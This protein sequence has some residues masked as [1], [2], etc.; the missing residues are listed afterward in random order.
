MRPRP[1]RTKTTVCGPSTC[2]CGQRTKILGSG[3]PSHEQIRT[4]EQDNNF[5]VDGWADG[6]KSSEQQTC[7]I[8]NQNR[9]LGTNQFCLNQTV[10]Q[11]YERTGH[12][13][14]RVA[15]PVK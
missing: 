11:A 6:R 7:S 12:M 5:E 14:E 1:P 13:S 3:R 2:P 8:R 10:D 9:R 15:C 4:T